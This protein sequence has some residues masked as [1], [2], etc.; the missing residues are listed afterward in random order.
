MRKQFIW[1]ESQQKTPRRRRP[2]GSQLN[3][4]EWRGSPT[5]GSNRAI[6]AEVEINW[7]VSSITPSH[8]TRKWGPSMLAKV[9]TH[10]SL[11]LARRFNW[12]KL[13]QDYGVP[14]QVPTRRM[15]QPKVRATSPKRCADKKAFTRSVFELYTSTGLLTAPTSWTAIE[16]GANGR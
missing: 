10:R 13:F 2:R 16:R 4:S 1:L 5:A 12:V 14:W 8:K 15:S 11:S 7:R 9:S 6:A 3:S